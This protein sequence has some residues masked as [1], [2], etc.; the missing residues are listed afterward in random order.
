M[1]TRL[2]EVMEDAS[3]LHHHNLVHPSETSLTEDLKKTDDISIDNPT[4]PG[5]M[6]D[7]QSKMAKSTL[8]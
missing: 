5:S 3:V 4:K 6:E 2:Q 1:L 8:E 7:V